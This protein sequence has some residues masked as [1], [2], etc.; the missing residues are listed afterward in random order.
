PLN[1]VNYTG[2]ADWV[3]TISST[4][5]FNLRVSGNRYIEEARFQDGL[6]YDITQLGFASG[7]SNQFS[8]KMFPRFELSDFVQLGRGSFSREVTNVYSVQPNLSMVLGAHT[9]RVGLDYRLQQYA[10]QAAGNG[11]MRLTFDRTFTQKDFNRTDPLSGSAIA[12]IL[13][14]APSGGNVDNNVF[15]IYMAKYYAPWIQEDWKVTRKLTIN[16]G[17]RWDVNLPGVERYNRI[18]Y[19]FDIGAVNPANSRINTALLINGLTR[20][21]GG[22]GFA[23]QGQA[24]VRPDWNNIQPSFGFAYSL[25]QKTVLRGGYGRYYVNPVGAPGYPTNGFSVQTP[26]VASTDS[27]RTPIANSLANPFPTGVLKP[28]GSSAGL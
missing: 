5:V 20:I 3:R 1:R 18:N 11:G 28:A 8:V 15:P 14:G 21:N 12:S 6:G 24:A 25:N 23:E 16:L 4:T 19:G 17:F 27:N 2:V 9:V 13:L 10:R 22:L 26:F 7:L